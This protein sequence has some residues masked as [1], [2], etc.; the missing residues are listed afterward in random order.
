ML[1]YADTVSDIEVLEAFD[2][3]ASSV[4]VL[5]LNSYDELTPA[6]NVGVAYSLANTIGYANGGSPAVSTSEYEMLA[7][8]VLTLG[9]SYDSLQPLNGHIKSFRYWPKFY[10]SKLQALTTVTD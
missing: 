9:N 1:H 6:I 10:P 5:Y 7:P 4:D 3:S 2:T 8:D